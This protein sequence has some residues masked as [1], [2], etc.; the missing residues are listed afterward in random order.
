MPVK[1]KTQKEAIDEMWEKIIGVNGGGLIETVSSHT[2]EIGEVKDHVKA[3]HGDVQYIRGKVDGHVDSEKPSKRHIALRRVLEVVAVAA[4]LAVVVV[5][6]LLLYL[7][8]LTPQDIVEIL[9]A[10]KG[11]P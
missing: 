7:G 8:K 6:G 3:V 2:N 1:P 11:A 4:V 5:G 9:E 10:Y